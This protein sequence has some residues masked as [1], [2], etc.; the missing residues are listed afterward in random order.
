MLTLF[1]V[2]ALGVYAW[3]KA[4]THT[5]RA[6]VALCAMV[7]V[8]AVHPGPGLAAVQGPQAGPSKPGSG[9]RCVR[10]PGPFSMCKG[11]EGDSRSGHRGK[12]RRTPEESKKHMRC[13]RLYFQYVGH[14]GRHTPQS[15]KHLHGC[16][17][18]EMDAQWH[19]ATDGYSALPG[20]SLPI[21]I[22]EEL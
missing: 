17:K 2:F 22:I 14:H 10:L 9:L 21:L 1:A 20:M 6:V 11:H 16:D 8:A 13:R 3:G 4:H 7:L 18:W 5:G 15:L 12:R 19:R